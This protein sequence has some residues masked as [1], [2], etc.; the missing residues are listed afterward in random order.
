MRQH[1]NPDPDL[2]STS[3]AERLNL[4]V[5]THNK[6][7]VRLTCAFSKKIANHICGFRPS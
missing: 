1:P 4:T 6:R 2:I 3:Y 5:R 7:F